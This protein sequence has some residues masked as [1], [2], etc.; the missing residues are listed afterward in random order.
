MGRI[1]EKKFI[2][3]ETMWDQTDG[4]ANQDMCSISYYLIYFLSKS[5]QIV[6]DRDIEKPGHG[7]D[8]VDGFNAV[9]KRYLDTLLRMH[10]TPEV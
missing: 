5:H 9:H 10:S 3:G 8:V 1:S 2:R 4:Y 6:L 7:K